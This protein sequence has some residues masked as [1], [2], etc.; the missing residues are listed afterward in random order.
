MALN[1]PKVFT[2]VPYHTIPYR[3]HHYDLLAI[4]DLHAC[5]CGCHFRKRDRE[6]ERAPGGPTIVLALT[7]TA[8]EFLTTIVP[9]QGAARARSTAMVLK[10]IVTRLKPARRRE[11][12]D[13]AGSTLMSGKET[14]IEQQWCTS[15]IT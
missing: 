11:H 10:A 13:D 5:A 7:A 12:R 3:C 14:R 2:T 15:P 1:K 9:E 8:V 4:I 6:G